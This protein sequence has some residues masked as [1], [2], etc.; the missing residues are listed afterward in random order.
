MRQTRVQG[1]YNRQKKHDSF[2]YIPNELPG[3]P[4]ERLLKVVVGLCRNLKVLQVLLPV[5][6]DCASLDFTLLKE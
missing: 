6:G 2:S 4:E 5:E 1:C 3:E